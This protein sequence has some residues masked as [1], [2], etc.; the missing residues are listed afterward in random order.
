MLSE[1]LTLFRK[2]GDESG[3]ASVLWGMGLSYFQAH[4]F[5]GAVPI[6]EE[7]E[8]LNRKLDNRFNL[9]WTLHTLGRCLFE[10]GDVERAR[11]KWLE[12]IHVFQSA[13][14][15]PGLLFQVDNFSVV[16]AHDGDLVRA[17]RLSA[18][19]KAHE[20]SS[21]AVLI[22]FVQDQLPRVDLDQLGAEKL[23]KAS[24]EGRAMTLDQAIAYALEGAQTKAPTT[25]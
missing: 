3:V 19:A 21:G 4:D 24:A 20:Q 13:G 17:A 25:T 5:R 22:N 16:A 14:D 7:T 15:V 9:G 2:V 6:L 23:A 18:A 11:G 12:A 1:A 10:L 8:A